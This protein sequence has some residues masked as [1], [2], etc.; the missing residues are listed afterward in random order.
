MQG[1]E[2]Q[3]PLPRSGGDKLFLATQTRPDIMLATSEVAQYQEMPTK[4][5]VTM[6]KQILRYLKG[7][8]DL[9][10]T[11]HK[12]AKDPMYLIVDANFQA[13]RSRSCFILMRAG[14]V[15]SMRTSKQSVPA[16]SSTEA[17]YHACTS[18]V[19]KL[20]WA[21]ELRSELGWQ[22]PGASRMQNDNTNTLKMAKRVLNTHRTIHLAVRDEFLHTHVENGNIEPHHIR[23]TEN[24]ADLGTKPLQKRIFWK[25]RATLM[26]ERP[27]NQFHLS[28]PEF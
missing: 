24:P 17:E 11:Y 10:I 26:G 6:V 8:V 19:Q 25:H 16:L 14:A 3:I 1:Y 21:R 9:G 12:D 28:T 2:H 18:G 5:N 23:T 7:S 27:T 20:I 15:V 22:E 4:E 13:P